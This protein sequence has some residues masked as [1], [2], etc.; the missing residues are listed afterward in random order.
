MAT[1]PSALDQLYD[2]M[3]S[4][5]AQTSGKSE[6]PTAQTSGRS[7]LDDLYD[8]MAAKP[9]APAA[10]SRTSDLITQLPKAPMP[11]P[12]ELAGKPEDLGVSSQWLPTRPVGQPAAGQPPD[13]YKGVATDYDLGKV[14]QETGQNI[15]NYL[16]ATG[17]GM[18]RD[19]EAGGSRVTVKNGK[20]VETPMPTPEEL[21][22]AKE[23]FQNPILAL[24]AG[25]QP[26]SVNEAILRGIEA[27]TSPE[28]IAIMTMMWPVGTGARLAQAGWDAVAIRTLHAGLNA[29]FAKNMG[30]ASGQDFYDAWDAYKKGDLDTVK[31]KL[32]QGSMEGLYTLAA[33]WGLGSDIETLRKTQAPMLPQTPTGQWSVGHGGGFQ[34]EPEAP[35]IPPAGE[36]PPAPGQLPPPTAPPETPAAAGAPPPETPAPTPGAPPAAPIPT[37]EEQALDFARQKLANGERVSESQLQ[38]NYKLGFGAAQQILAQARTEQTPPPTPNTPDTR[39]SPETPVQA[40]SAS[41]PTVPETPE[42]LG[43]QF[44]QLGNQQRRVV[45]I[46]KGTEGPGAETYP[47]GTRVTHDE[48]GNVYVYWPWSPENPNG[49]KSSDI[50]KAVRENRLPEILGGATMGLGAKDKSNLPPNPPVVTVHSPE[51]AEVQS[52]ATAPEDVASTVHAAQEVTPEG[53]TITVQSPEQALSER[54]E[55]AAPPPTPPPPET[56]AAPEPIEKP[57]EAPPT[58]PTPTPTGAPEQFKVGQHVL[59]GDTPAVVTDAPPYG[60]PTVR[61]TGGGQRIAL[62]GDIRSASNEEILNQLDAQLKSVGKQEIALTD[63]LERRRRSG[64]P[65]RLSNIVERQLKNVRAQ[66]REITNAIQNLKPPE[67]EK[68]EAPKPIEKPP[69][70][71][72]PPPTAP[73]PETAAPPEEKLEAPKPIEEAKPPEPEVEKPPAKPPS[74]REV[75][76]Q[77][78]EG[79]VDKFGIGD[80]ISQLTAAGH[81]PR[82]IA[83]NLAGQL[84]SY[85]ARGNTT[86]PKLFE[87]EAMV[88]AHRLREAEM[89]GNPPIEGDQEALDKIF[90]RKNV[91][92]EETAPKEEEKPAE[93]LTAPEPVEKPPAVT[94][95]PLAPKPGTT[96]EMLARYDE[97]MTQATNILRRTLNDSILL[98]D[99]DRKAAQRDIRSALKNA[100][101]IF[102]KTP[103]SQP[104]RDEMFRLIQR[105]QQLLEGKAPEKAPEPVESPSPVFGD[106]VQRF[107]EEGAP[108]PDFSKPQGIYT[109]PAHL[110]SPHADIGG[111]R[112]LWKV[113]PD[114]KVLHF[115]STQFRNDDVVMR[116]H[117]VSAGTGVWAV[118]HFLGQGKLDEF[119]KQSKAQLAKT[120]REQFPDIHVDW[121]KYFD[122]QEMVEGLGG[123]LARKAGYDA[124]ELV[125]TRDPRWSEY[126]GLTPKSMSPVEEKLAAPE[127]I[128]HPE[129]APTE[130]TP[131]G[132]VGLVNAVYTKLKNGESL[133]NVTELTKLAEENFGASRTSGIWSP[134]DMFDAMEAGVNKY[135]MDEGKRLMNLPV[136]EGLT[137]LRGLMSRITTQGV[138]TDEQIKN[139]QFSTPPTEAYLAARVANVK[140][141]DV[142]LEP[143]AG[144]GGLAVW[145]ASIGA[146]VHVNE[147]APRRQEMLKAAGFDKPT[148]HDGELINALLPT[149][150]KPTVV[151]MNP[152]FSA[153]TTK[154]HAAANANRYGYNHVLQA[155]QRLEPGGRLVAILGGGQANEPNG[156]ASLTGGE[157]GKFFEKIAQAPLGTV[158]A[159]VRINGKEYQKYGTS[160]ATRLVVIDKSVDADVLAAPKEERAKLV[161]DRAIKGNVD[162][163]EEAY[164]LL[165]PLITSGA[166]VGGPTEEVQPRPGGE[167]GTG[168]GQPGVGVAPGEEP[169]SGTAGGRLPGG[170]GGTQEGGVSG[171]PTQL[172]G[173]PGPSGPGAGGKQPS[174]REPR[175][176]PTKPPEP[177][178][179][180]HPEGAPEHVDVERPLDGSETVGDLKLSESEQE[181]AAQ[182]EEDSEA[183][184]TYKPS[185]KGEAHP[186]SIV[187]TKTMSTVPLPPIT[188]EPNL[189]ASVIEG[190]K[191]S[192]VQLEAIA[193]AGQQN[194]IILPGGFRASV[195]IGDGT[196]VGKGREAAGILWDNWRRGRK[197]LFWVS[198]SWDLMQDALDAFSGIGADELMQGMQKQGHRWAVTGKNPK[199]IPLNKF[200]VKKDLDHE[201]IIYT[202]YAL[203]RSG[204][205]KGNKR[206]AQIEK[207]LKGN[208]N[209]EGGYILFDEAHN[210]KNAVVA[211]GQQASQIGVAVKELLERIPNLRTASLSGTAA[212]DVMNL[213]YLDRL[214][215]WGPGTPFPNGFAQFANEV[216]S[217]GLAAMEMIAQ[218]LK[219]EGKYLSRTLSFK[220]V[221]YRE[222]E[223]NLNEDQKALYR[224]AT[225]AWN[226]VHEHALATVENQTNGG[227]RQRNNFMSQLAGAQLRFYGVLISALKIPTAIE[228]ANKA[229]AQNKSVVITL[230]NTNEAAQNREKNRAKNRDDEDEGDIQEFDFGPKETLTNLIKEHYPTQQYVDDVDDAGNPV[231]KPLYIEDENGNKVPVQN[232]AAVAERDALVAQINRDL[233]LPEN[234][235]DLLVQGLGGYGKVAEMTGRKEYFDRDSQKFVP[236]GDPNIPRKEI[237]ISEMNNFNGGKKRVAILSGAAG[238]GISLH[239]G[240]NFKNQQQRVHITLQVGWSADKQMQMFGRTQRTNQAHPP[241]YV[242]LVSDLA[243]EKRF[244]STIARRLGSLGAITKGQKNATTG[245]DLMEK[246]NF[247]TDQGRQA[248]NSFFDGLLRNEEIPGTGGLRGHSILQELRLLKTTPTGAVSVDPADRTNVTRLLNRLQNIDPD[249]QNAVYNYFY[250]IFQAVV[251][252][253]IERGTLDT[254]AKTLPGDTFH[255]KE[256]RVIA[257]N[258]DTGAK[259]FYYPVD[260]SVR[261]VRISPQDLERR[262]RANRETNAR[263]V[264]DGKRLY[265]LRDAPPIVHANGDVEPASYMAT[266]ANGKW[267]KVS[268]RTKEVTD[269]QDP[270]KY[271]KRVFDARTSALNNAKHSYEYQ[272]RQYEASLA[273]ERERRSVNPRYLVDSLEGQLRAGVAE[274]LRPSREAALEKARNDLKAAQE[275]EFPK[276]DYRRSYYEGAQERLT[277]AQ[278]ELDAVKDAA[279]DPETWADKKWEE[280][281][282]AAPVHVTQ[283]HHMI[284]GS[285]MRYW[286]LLKD[287]TT[288]RN[289]V[290]T[291]TDTKTGKRI[292]GIDIPENQIQGVLNQIAGGKSTVTADQMEVDVLRH[293]LQYE[294]TGGTQVKRGR[295]AGKHV[296]QIIPASRDVGENLLSVGVRYERGITPVYYLP[297]NTNPDKGVT[298]GQ[299]LQRVLKEYPVKSQPAATV[300]SETSRQIP[301]PLLSHGR[302]EPYQP[303]A[304]DLFHAKHSRYEPI[305]LEDPEDDRNAVA[306]VANPSGMEY[307]ARMNPH[308]PPDETA[309]W[310]HGHHF[311]PDQLGTLLH[312]IGADRAANMLPALAAL[313]QAAG[314]ARRTGKSLIVIKDHALVPEGQRINALHEEL[315][316]ALQRAATG[317]PNENHLGELAKPFL[318]SPLGSFAKQ[319]LENEYGYSFR[320]PGHVASEIGERLMRAGGYSEL[321]LTASEAQTLGS[322]YVRFLE[323]EYGRAA[324]EP[325]ARRVDEA[326][327]AQD[328]AGRPQATRPPQS[329][330][331]GPGGVGHRDRSTARSEGNRTQPEE[332][333][334]I[335]LGSGL[336]AVQPYLEQFGEEKLLPAL[337]K[338]AQG[339]SEIF[340]EMRAVF[341][342]QTRG[343]LAQVAA[344]RYREYIGSLALQ[345]ARTHAALEG[346]RNVLRELPVEHGVYGLDVIDAIE[347]GNIDQLPDG[348]IKDFAKTARE[349]LDARKDL[350][351]KLG[352]VRSFIDNYFPH[353]WKKPETAEQWAG[354]WTSKKPLAGKEEFRK[355]RVYPTMRE[356]LEDPDFNME[357]RYTDPIDFLYASISQMDK[358]IY[359]HEMLNE[360][361]E[362]GYLKFSR[363]KIAPLGYA[364]VNDKLFTAKGPKY[365]AVQVPPG[366]VTLPD[367]EELTPSQ[368]RVY[369]DRT[370]G[371]HYLPEQMAR[372]INNDLSPNWRNKTW[373]KAY[374]AVKGA[375][376]SA[377][378]GFSAFHAATTTLNSVFSDWALGIK[379]ILEGKPIRGAKAIGRAPLSPVL[380]FLKGTYLEKVYKG[381]IKNPK[382]MDLEIVEA[383]KKAGYSPAAGHTDFLKKLKKA[384]MEDR[385]IQATLHAVNPLLWSQ[386]TT[387]HIMTKLVPRIK[388]AAFAKAASLA[389]QDHPDMT[390]DEARKVFG[391]I[392]NSMDNRMGLL[393]QRNMFMEGYLRDMMNVVVGRPGWNIGTVRELLGGAMDA[394]LNLMDLARGKKPTISHRTA[395]LLAMLFG[396]A[397]IN[398]LANFLLSGSAPHGLDYIFPRDGGTD[399]DGRPS[400]II[401]PM[402]LSKDI[403]SWATRGLATFKA[404][405]AQPLMVGSDLFINNRDFQDRKILG[406][407]GIGLEKYLRESFYPYAYTGLQRQI[408]RGEPLK[409]KLLPFAGILPASR[410]VSMSKAEKVLAEYQDEQY[411]KVR[412]APTAHTEARNQVYQ[413]AKHDPA[414]AK[415]MGDEQVKAGN[416]SRR[417]VK[418][419]IERAKESPLEWNVKHFA[420]KDSNAMDTLME[421][422]DK[423]T[424]DERKQIQREVRKKVFN[425][426]GQA[427]KW[428]PES[429][430]LATKNFGT[431]FYVPRGDLSAPAEMQ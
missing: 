370:M 34:P 205:T 289:S 52:T 343:K 20:V 13:S 197:R 188:Y 14:G 409:N 83:Q 412:P 126:V 413:T 107:E 414:A 277:Q 423:A 395:Y 345:E 360:L 407:G 154:S 122:T 150:V 427:F 171:G 92:K 400:R 88:L 80:K 104:L 399:E 22:R 405:L 68:L 194:E 134:K 1:A 109:T 101:M 237:N 106:T 60:S 247:E 136:P 2:E 338:G 149:E 132:A 256:S 243:G 94:A 16:A 333:R 108:R 67:E 125:D 44:Q 339:A 90:D 372:I 196:G 19:P 40:P 390:T 263:V 31:N 71:E 307:L 24:H 234:P 15:Y 305:P 250:D 183:Y 273:Q 411:A 429:R 160:F 380:D 224:T 359:A 226:T 77:K 220:G 138:R 381:E 189:P 193:L 7:A 403:Y 102:D 70:P 384:W 152:P 352:L 302:E 368:I 246:V 281:Y 168:E 369:G 6:M 392:L 158:R 314:E 127:P 418:N 148:S 402:Y 293:G 178:A 145:P 357:P 225:K 212:T 358:S 190:A 350:L 165:N 11:V 325:I 397:L 111:E 393:S 151:L 130:E 113:N 254:G 156:G 285:V 387:H 208:D 424:P 73:P 124:M 363:S 223:H 128:E 46:P 140:P 182:R 95:P 278:N 159:N 82:Q 308:V 27:P 238:T 5:S 18:T 116:P 54:A 91:P 235:L 385:K 299:I 389:L 176:E 422:Y 79:F 114:A 206:A 248:T 272:Q 417:D 162:T 373:F 55:G 48:Y 209:G 215:M 187:E 199:I 361:A 297:T 143:S 296:I 207:Y 356:A 181:A 141:S 23:T 103:A 139:Q 377:N 271:I 365:G 57:P 38:R 301:T 311:G 259:S 262:L 72:A 26:G 213:G 227:S 386:I 97:F 233:H 430:A 221:T 89:F 123:M 147:I 30:K 202:T 63:E 229:L 313:E 228:E 112:S 276:D 371:Y 131:K 268:N 25:A 426:K 174:P 396:G 421:A 173:A 96:P 324:T 118:R 32:A 376:N 401:L 394:G 319:H 241:E 320:S 264:T 280:A 337:K 322:Q 284:G 340:D 258:K 269:A 170:G 65:A 274:D 200:D 195:L 218:E 382:P 328:A 375:W 317:V 49:L 336:G 47:D 56:L 298:Q 161:A 312:N 255:I 252:D 179:V 330:R 185:V 419:A 210:L 287:A 153:S 66:M 362:D 192:A 53:G 33:M 42:T 260:A 133:G 303:G 316:H 327:N 294:L 331:E 78:L 292:V 120:L 288:I 144:N 69:T 351:D 28:N 81:T 306:L 36:I 290:Y 374:M 270:A 214:G 388:L 105:G 8:E 366:S 286:N 216:A 74:P 353:M 37:P 346:F 265:I 175:P 310:V 129:T 257:T 266:P 230:V 191:L 404:K 3:S 211:R 203:L 349:L 251:Q 75:T 119:R 245:T 410:R 244:V 342:P 240:L 398:G 406:K 169:S 236:R 335:Y 355:R 135:L 137:E 283:T 261:T 219:A 428:T 367:E 167:T 76:R 204:D 341:A 425:A 157:S 304:S 29:Y 180:K 354:N 295:V 166:G 253:A 222:V 177:E 364:Q 100:G 231:K 300:V 378:L 99:T 93:Q 39:I 9:S 198:Q 61:L 64:E 415:R 184:V 201:G 217:N 344:G 267:Q 87:I 163:L 326:Q 84:Q 45:M 85:D 279:E 383:L 334:G 146:K 379:D 50:H 315:N 232:P 249:I 117:A 318:E 164:G 332:S 323:E 347:G 142:V 391:D 43:I 41:M 329:A 98:L 239:A 291:A 21:T 35:P 110:E 10:P 408:A 58:P 420:V 321:G 431:K 121:G 51:G 115:E 62:P 309:L 282:N 12:P 4:A 172:G 186:G 155:L 242:M 275:Y 348:P 86:G 416:L 59:Y 17:R